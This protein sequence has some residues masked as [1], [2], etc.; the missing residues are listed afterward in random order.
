MSQENIDSPL[1]YVDLEIEKSVTVR[2]AFEGISIFGGTGSGKTTGSGRT[3][4]LSMLEKGWGGLVLTV[5]PDE[6]E[7]WQHY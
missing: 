4:A 1:F 3:I 6:R 5:K 7:R 2:Q